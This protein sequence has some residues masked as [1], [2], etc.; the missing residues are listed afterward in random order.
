MVHHMVHHMVH[1]KVHYIVHYIVQYIVTWSLLFKS[2]KVWYRLRTS[3]IE[4]ATVGCKYVY[5]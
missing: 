2:V 5:S 4:A 1:Y 3:V